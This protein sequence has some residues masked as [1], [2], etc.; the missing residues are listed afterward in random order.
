MAEFELYTVTCHYVS[1]TK[2]RYAR[3]RDVFNEKESRVGNSLEN[4]SQVI[5]PGRNWKI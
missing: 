2:C 5:D 3:D 1:S 4:P